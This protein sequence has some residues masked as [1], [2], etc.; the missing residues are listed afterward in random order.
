MSG[1]IYSNEEE[2]QSVI[3]PVHAH[4]ASMLLLITTNSFLIGEETHAFN[5]S[6]NS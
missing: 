5:K 4:N 1:I 6:L 2:L 3:T